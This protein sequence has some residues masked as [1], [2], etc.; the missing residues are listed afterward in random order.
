MSTNYLKNLFEALEIKNSNFNVGVEFYKKF[1]Y[2]SFILKI[3]QNFYNA[4]KK[5]VIFNFDVLFYKFISKTTYHNVEVSDHNF[6]YNFNSLLISDKVPLIINFLI[7]SNESEKLS[8][9]NIS[10]IMEQYS[11]DI[12]LIVIG[13][14]LIENLKISSFF[15][16]NR[17]MLNLLNNKIYIFSLD[18]SSNNM[19]E[20]SE[21]RKNLI[22]SKLDIYLLEKLNKQIDNKLLLYFEIYNLK[23]LT[24]E[25][26]I[27]E[28]LKS[29]EK[30]LKISNNFNFEKINV[31][32]KEFKDIFE[33]QTEA[34]IE[35]VSTFKLTL[36]EK[37]IKEKNDII[38]PYLK[39]QDENR[40]IIDQEDLNELYEEDPDGDLDI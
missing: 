7:F 30:N 1:T 29:N 17:T 23:K 34:E 37:E 5:I 26:S 31:Y 33:I 12:C 2:Y 6:K 9:K 28:F 19:N 21:K 11:N 18:S 40:I 24:R 36:N 22:K 32:L 8:Y 16:Y 13:L 38:L 27:F 15:L 39:S 20:E 3:L 25:I 35:P 10:N 14:D 4:K